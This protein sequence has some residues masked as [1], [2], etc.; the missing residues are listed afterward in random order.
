MN[1]S[2]ISKD[3]IEKNLFTTLGTL[4]SRA[5]KNSWWITNNYTTLLNDLQEKTNHLDENCKLP[6]R[7]HCIY[8]NIYTAPKCYCGNNAIFNSF[9]HGYK[10]YCSKTCAYKS[11]ERNDKMI[12]N[13]NICDIMQKMKKTHLNKYGVEHYYQSEEFKLKSKQTK[14]IQYNDEYY[15]NRDK[16]IQTNLEKYGVEYSCQ[17]DEVRKKM[18]NTKNETN[19]E[20]RDKNWLLEQ[21]K[22]KSVAEIAEILNVSYRTVYL[23]FEKHNI[24][25]NFFAS[26]Y[27][28]EQLELHNFIESLG[29]KNIRY[30]DRTIIKPKELDIFLPDYNLAIEYNGMYWHSEDRNRHI[31]K[32]HLCNEQNI[33]LLQFWDM[34]WKYKQNIVKS[35][36]KSK[37]NLNTTIYARK[38]DIATINGKTYNNFLIDNHIQG[39]INSSLKYGL[40]HQNELV[41]VIGLGKS[42]YD[43]KHSHE[44]LRFCNK[45]NYNIV[46]GFSKLLKH[47][48][49]NNDI[50]SLQTFCDLRLFN[51]NVYENTGFE[52]S[53]STK[54][55]YVYYKN[56]IIANRIKFQKHKLHTMFEDFNP[57][58][59]EKENCKNN[60]WLQVFDCGQKI[61]VMKL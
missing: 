48:I 34:E 17:A 47:A 31:N 1:N 59:S 18:E 7:L 32:L 49:K 29:I 9:K 28:K 5:C 58:L 35:I 4:N 3:W 56:D 42:R 61:Y 45:I 15:C 39:N 22:T 53:H 24:E 21:N 51:G 2:K 50:T 36:I 43:R 12:A 25:P 57:T 38:C 23:W 44:L 19:P 6:E 60:G 16:M 13:R 40:Y 27:G 37:L 30:N 11:D 14:L 54:P 26:Y 8:N 52:Y 20:L 33:T 10:K 46:G 55:G 41:A